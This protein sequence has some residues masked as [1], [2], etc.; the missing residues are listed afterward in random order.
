MGSRHRIA[1][2]P[3]F[4]EQHVPP[5][6]DRVFSDREGA[7]WLGKGYTQLVVGLG[8]ERGFEVG[9]RC[10]PVRDISTAH[11]HRVLH[12]PNRLI[13]IDPTVCNSAHV[14]ADS[15]PTHTADILLDM[16]AA[17][18]VRSAGSVNLEQLR[19]KARIARR[20]AGRLL[21]GTL[22]D[23]ARLCKRG[24]TPRVR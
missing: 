4:E 21:K 23:R 13:D 12:V 24:Q 8:Q 10:A 9:W 5:L 2:W 1:I 15:R 3:G 16:H 11:T 6:C 19:L 7:A 20:I 14:D 22:Q 18:D 17:A